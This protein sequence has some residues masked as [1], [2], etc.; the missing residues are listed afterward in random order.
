[1]YTYTY[2]VNGREWFCL[3][4]LELSGHQ[5][6]LRIETSKTCHQKSIIFQLCTICSSICSMESMA[7]RSMIHDD[8]TIYGPG[9]WVNLA[10]S[11]QISKKK[12]KNCLGIAVDNSIL[13][14]FYASC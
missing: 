5:R 12:L 11:N 14:V 2:I 9:L 7:Y 6:P 3:N 8:P 13:N 4:N 10:W 1:M